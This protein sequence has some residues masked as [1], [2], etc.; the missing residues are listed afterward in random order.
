MIHMM[1]GLIQKDLMDY[2]KRVLTA[3][4]VLLNVLL[5]GSNN[6]TFSARNWEWRKQKKLNVVI[7]IDFV[8]G[9]G[10][11]LECWISWK[12]RRKW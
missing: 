9:K 8:I 1:T 4:S 5:G 3:L 11:C 10:H 7:L 6:Q 2:I 12:V